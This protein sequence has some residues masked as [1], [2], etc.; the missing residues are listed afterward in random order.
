MDYAIADGPYSDIN[1][2]GDEFPY[3]SVTLE[4]E[5]E[6]VYKQYTCNTRQEA[7]D[8]ALSFARAEHIEAIIEAGYA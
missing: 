8:T 1:K 3:W 7:I 4:D 6:L 5:N 2:W